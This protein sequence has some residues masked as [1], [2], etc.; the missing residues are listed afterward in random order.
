MTNFVNYILLFN[1]CQ[2]HGVNIYGH[3]FGEM[4]NNQGRLAS[5]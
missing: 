3:I 1:H 2:P 5:I 4:G